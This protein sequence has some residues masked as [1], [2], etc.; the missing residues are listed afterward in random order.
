[1]NQQPHSSD[2][3]QYA[4]SQETGSEDQSL[5]SLVRQHSLRLRQQHSP[6]QVKEHRSSKQSLPSTGSFYGKRI[7]PLKRIVSNPQSLQLD[8]GNNEK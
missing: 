7:E 4:E 6:Q 3:H 5:V 1:M 8:E 2:Q